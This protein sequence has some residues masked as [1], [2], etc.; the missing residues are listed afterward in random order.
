MQVDIVDVRHAEPTITRDY[1]V[2]KHTREGLRV[3]NVTIII[4]TRQLRTLALNATDN[5]SG[6]AVLFYGAVKAKVQP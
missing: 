4:D 3:T 6:E 2:I 1:R 5:A